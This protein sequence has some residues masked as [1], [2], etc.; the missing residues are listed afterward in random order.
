M[1]ADPTKEQLPDDCASKGKGGDIGLRWGG[2]IS[3]A[4]N[5]AQ[6]GIDL[7]NDSIDYPLVSIFSPVAFA[8][9]M[10]THPLR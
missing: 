3:A 6:H 5:L 7:A 9:T 10:W 8:G 2:F 1:I 4:I